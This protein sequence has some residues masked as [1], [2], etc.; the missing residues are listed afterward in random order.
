MN[1]DQNNEESK[2]LPENMERVE[3]SSEEKTLFSKMGI[4]FEDDKLNVDFN[5]TRD[6]FGNLQKQL[7]ERAER[8]Q[9]DISEGSVDMSEKVG[10]KVDKNHINVDLNKSREF[11]ND[12][13]KKI[14][15]FLTEIDKVV[16]DVNKK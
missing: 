11:I 4:E 13:G 9:K 10:I 14:E 5:Q 2:N 1:K 12:F 3:S 15:G 16:H 8:I 7:E 6:F